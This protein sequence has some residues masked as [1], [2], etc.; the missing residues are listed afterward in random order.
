MACSFISGKVGQSPT[1]SSLLPPTVA[2]AR[3]LHHSFHHVQD[4]SQPST[5]A[6]TPLTYSE[7]IYAFPTCQWDGFQFPYPPV[8][9]RDVV[10]KAIWAKRAASERWQAAISRQ[11]TEGFDMVDFGVAVFANAMEV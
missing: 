9:D 10:R 3:S 4:A 5:S 6:Q 7:C 1:S 8:P 2:R 11:S